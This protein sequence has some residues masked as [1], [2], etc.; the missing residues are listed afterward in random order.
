VVRV[1]GLLN[2]LGEII[3]RMR[4]RNKRAT[5]PHLPPLPPGSTLAVNGRRTIDP[6][7]YKAIP[8]PDSHPKRLM[9]RTFKRVV[10]GTLG[11]LGLR[12]IRV[13]P[14]H[15][16]TADTG[17]RQILRRLGVSVVF[18]VGAHAGEY[19]THLRDIGY[20]GRIIS[21]EPQAGAFAALSKRAMFDPYWEP[22]HM[23]LGDRQG[24]RVLNISRN[25]WSSSFL[26]IHPQI[27]DVEEALEKVG[28]ERVHVQVLDKIYRDLIDPSENKIFLKIDAQG[29]EP[30]VL[31][32]AREF[33]SSCV[34]VQL[35]MALLP[36]YQDQT[37][38][39]EMI[40]LMRKSGFELIHLERGFWDYRT[41]YLVETDGIFVR[42]EVVEEDFPRNAATD[43][44]SRN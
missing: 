30:I 11:H 6:F 28:T 17:F 14:D 15:A 35:E 3:E 41:G 39:P 5:I 2:G 13:D 19:A 27:L 21:F 42:A 32:G 34:A 29:Y 25:S 22:L 23:A 26:P 20:Q 33:L 12:L 16:T 43:S 1:G 37:L 36:S 18:D 4:A 9:I 40:V 8:I 31:A 7:S 10:N 44:L 38:L 24:E